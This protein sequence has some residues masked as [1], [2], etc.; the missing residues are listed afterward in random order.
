[1]SG[2]SPQER[3]TPARELLT[4][5]DGLLGRPSKDTVGLWPRAATLLTRQALEVA[6]KTFWSA[7]ARG[8]EECT[9]RAQLLCLG[10]YL[11]DEALAQ[12]A[13]H[14]WSA[15]SRSCH[16]HPYDLAPTREEIAAWHAVV[17][18]VVERTERAW[19]R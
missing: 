15:L 19:R 11:G 1:M 17:A 18:E 9:A 6:L 5:V 16:H 10:R 2:A 14:V 12:R 13:H 3:Q 4:A 8:V 7:K